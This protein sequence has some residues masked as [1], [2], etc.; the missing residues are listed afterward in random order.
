MPNALAA[1]SVI[2]GTVLPLSLSTSFVETFAFPILSAQYHDNTIERSLIT[3]GINTPVPARTWKLAKRLTA[4][5]LTTLR[6]FFENSPTDVPAGVQAGSY[7][8]YFYEI[9]ATYD[10][11]GV[12]VIGRVTVFFRGNWA[13]S[14]GIG[15]GDVPNLEL[16]QVI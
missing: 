4:A 6:Q 3:D 1:A 2:P 12:S 13:H 11:T 10:P 9:D 15:R 8:F 16:V 14:L 5:Q 7:P